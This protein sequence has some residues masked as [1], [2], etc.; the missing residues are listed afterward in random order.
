ELEAQPHVYIPLAQDAGWGATL[1]VRARSGR[2]EALL[3]S[4]RAAIARVDPDRP[5]NRVRTLA[6]IGREATSRPRMRAAIV[7]AFAALA[8]GIGVLGVF[9]VTAFSVEQRLREFGVRMT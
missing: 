4:V 8:L 1:V 9:A 6:G 7:G 3:R 5:V 2:A